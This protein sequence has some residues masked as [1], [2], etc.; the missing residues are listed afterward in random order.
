MSFKLPLSIVASMILYSPVQAQVSPKYYGPNALPVP[1]MIEGKV[2]SE[3]YGELAF[4]VYK[5]FYDDVTRTISAR[6]NIPLFTSRVNLSVWMPVVEFYT[7]TPESLVWQHS[8]KQKIKGYEIGN[9]YIS[10]DIQ[11]LKQSGIKP[12]IVVRAALITASGDSEEYARY[13]D[14]PGY[15]FDVSLSK[16]IGFSRGFFTCL[17]FTA[18]GGFLC[19]QTGQSVQNDA[20]M[21]GVKVRLNTRV[22]SVAMAWQGYNG[23]QDN[24]DRPMVLRADMIFRAGHISPI[25]AYEYGIRDYPYHHFRI[26]LGCK[27]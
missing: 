4:D 17:R 21:Y 27:F 16:S 25:L 19:W 23:W 10:T 3:L 5:G 26:G 12:D 7:N 13:Y 24:G 15:F 2:S 20:Y 8:A 14:A 22:F 11:V 18:N 1:E 6:L 9:V